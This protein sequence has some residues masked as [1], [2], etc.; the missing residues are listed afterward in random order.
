VGFRG[1][2]CESVVLKFR[3]RL[4]VDF[5]FAFKVTPKFLTASILQT[6]KR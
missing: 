3:R 6:K 1:N 5:G 2:N 4:W